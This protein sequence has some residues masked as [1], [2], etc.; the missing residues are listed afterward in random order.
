MSKTTQI[1]SNIIEDRNKFRESQSRDLALN[2]RPAIKYTGHIRPLAPISI[3]FFNA[4]KKLSSTTHHL[5]KKDENFIDILK[6]K[7]IFIFK[8][9]KTKN[10][11]QWS[12]WHRKRNDNQ[13]NNDTE[14]LSSEFFRLILPY[15]PKVRSLKDNINNTLSIISKKS[16]GFK[17]QYEL[18]STEKIK[19]AKGIYTGLGE[20]LVMILF[21]NETDAHPG[22]IGIDAKGRFIKIDGGWGFAHTEDNEKYNPLTESMLNQLP[23]QPA[24]FNGEWPESSGMSSNPK[25]RRE[26]NH[27]ILRIITLSD[28]F[29]KVFVDSYIA[30]SE[31]NTLLYHELLLRKEA[32]KSIALKNSSFMS[33]LQTGQCEVDYADH[34]NCLKQFK[35]TGKNVPLTELHLNEMQEIFGTLKLE[36]ILKTPD[37][38]TKFSAPLTSEELALIETPKELS[39]P[40]L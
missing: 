2:P 4:S 7:S 26:V 17:D 24:D 21:I 13:R 9:S 34:V 35:T 29:L 18:N 10:I 3:G 25:F 30:D 39:S 32:L 22:N 38:W 23:H 1:R 37:P 8:K 19:M 12:Q 28:T 40:S 33:Y 15:H 20:I 36:N 6:E 31:T 5:S 16:E 14:V 27:G 11:N